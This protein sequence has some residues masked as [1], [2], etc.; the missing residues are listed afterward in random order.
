MHDSTEE[1]IEV[2]DKLKSTLT[3]RI[4]K[5]IQVSKDITFILDEKQYSL[6]QREL[7]WSAWKKI[8]ENSTTNKN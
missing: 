7:Y 3:N 5:V 4:V 6:T 1:I 2:G 8:Y